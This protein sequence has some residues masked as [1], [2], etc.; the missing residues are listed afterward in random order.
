MDFHQVEI[1]KKA[2]GLSGDKAGSDS[3]LGCYQTA[4][5]IIE[6]E[7]G[8]ETQ[9]KYRADTKKWST[10]MP[11]PLVQRWYVHTNYSSWEQ[12]TLL[13][14]TRNCEKHGTAAIYGF[15]KYVY[16][17][18]GMYMALVFMTVASPT[19]FSEISVG[20]GN[21]KIPSL[22]KSKFFLFYLD[23]LFTK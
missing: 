13:H 16:R 15:A 8:E 23:Y 12:V 17:H 10:W 5:N 11:P 7:L 4:Y 6:K 21:V 1:D 2:A 19:Q 18:F 9:I 14:Q 22:E 3:Y 20:G